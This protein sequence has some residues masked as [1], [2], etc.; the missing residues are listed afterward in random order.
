MNTQRIQQILI[1]LSCSLFAIFMGTWIA[2]GSWKLPLAILLIGCY[3]LL[4]KATKVTPETYVLSF[5]VFGYIV[6]NR[7]FA[8]ITPLG[9]LPLFM[10]EIGLLVGAG[11]LAFHIALKKEFPFRLD[12]L[13]IAIIIWIIV[14]SIR[15]LFDYPNYGIL[16]LRDYAMVYYSAFYF[17]AQPMAKDARSLNTFLTFI[18]IAVLLLIPGFLLFQTYPE[19]FLYYLVFDGAPIIYYKGDLVAF[20]FG[21]GFIIYYYQHTKTLSTFLVLYSSLFLFLSIYTTVRAAWI[22]LAS[23]ILLFYLSN[24]TNMIKHAFIGFL[25]LIPTLTIYCGIFA[26]D[27][28]QTRPYAIYEHILSIVDIS[29]RGTYRN[30]E[31]LGTGANNQYRLQW[32]KVILVDTIKNAP[33]TG[34]GFGHDL[35]K[36]FTLSFYNRFEQGSPVRS[37]HSI[38]LTVFGRLGLIGLIFFCLIIYYIVASTYREVF[39]VRKSANLTQAFPYW[40]ICWFIFFTACFGVILE[41]PMGGIVFWIFLGIAKSLSINYSHKDKPVEIP[42]LSN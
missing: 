33:I 1:V 29:G 17:I 9:N 34:M 10:G 20:Y 12:A 30:N 39:L 13:G 35:S 21:V 42:Y 14:G 23:S 36:Q 38:I 27:F 5:L 25:I 31:S 24:K 18:K 26:E 19:F 32:W 3:F 41:G 40:C 16:A 4:V 15:V 6:G 2:E 37:P 7:G 11:F 22:G 8:Q 28:R